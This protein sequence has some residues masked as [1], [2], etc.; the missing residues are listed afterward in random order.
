VDKLNFI[1]KFSGA[2]AQSLQD[3]WSESA[4][5]YARSSSYAGFACVSMALRGEIPGAHQSQAGEAMMTD[6][7]GDM[8]TRIRNGF[9]RP[10][11]EKAW[12]CRASKLKRNEL[13]RCCKDEG[14]I[15]RT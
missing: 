12:R 5:L 6:P 2:T 13:P 14:Y 7:I 9:H 10:G 15:D 1:V 8:L 11:K 3:V 4:G